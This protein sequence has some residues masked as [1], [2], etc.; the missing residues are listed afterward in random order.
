[1]RSSSVTKKVATITAAAFILLALTTMAVMTT[2]VT[3][4]AGSSASVTQSVTQSNNDG[5]S[6]VRVTQSGDDDDGSSSVSSSVR[7]TQSG[8]DDGSSSVRVTQS[9]GEGVEVSCEGDV[10]CEVIGDDTVVATS[11]DGDSITST[12]V[13]TTTPDTTTTV[14]QPDLDDLDDRM[15]GMVDRLL[16]EVSATLMGYYNWRLSLFT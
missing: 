1:M 3:A 15:E 8:D 10:N 2:F 9:N 11:E 5:T 13:T 6:S 7:V 16:D 14:N 12:A 4:D